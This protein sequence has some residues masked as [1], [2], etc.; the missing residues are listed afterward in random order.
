MVAKDG[1]EEKEHIKPNIRN[2]NEEK[3]PSIDNN[4]SNDIFRGVFGGS[5][6]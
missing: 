2:K 6:G 3:M 4:H 1:S 5:G